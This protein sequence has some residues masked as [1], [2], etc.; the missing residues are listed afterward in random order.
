[1]NFDLGNKPADNKKSTTKE[2]SNEE[3]EMKMT[4]SA[5]VAGSDGKK[6]VRVMFER[7]VNGEVQT[8]EGVLPDAKI[9][10]HNGYEDKEIAAME[11]YL[12]QNSEDIMKKAKVIS[13]PLHWF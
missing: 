12:S 9:V 3:P 1:M 6:V 5:L 4:Y 8:A 7:V 2:G 13:N 10:K 11:F